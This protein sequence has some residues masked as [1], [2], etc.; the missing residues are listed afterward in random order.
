MSDEA[1]EKTEE[2]ARSEGRV[3]SS[4]FNKTPSRP[5]EPTDFVDSKETTIDT[6]ENTESSDRDKIKIEN[7]TQ[8]L[9]YSSYESQVEFV[10]PPEEEKVIRIES[11]SQNNSLFNEICNMDSSESE[12]ETH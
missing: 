1:A 3:E 5:A 10:K 7:L 4:N 8:P 12:G 11:D 2:T 9:N 6:R